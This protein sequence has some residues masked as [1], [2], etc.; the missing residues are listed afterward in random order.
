[1][2][3]VRLQI[4]CA[5]GEETRRALEDILNAVAQIDARIYEKYPLAPCCPKCANMRYQP[6]VKADL[7]SATET[8]QTVDRMMAVRAVRC[9]AL[10]AMVA[11]HEA[12]Q[13]VPATV[14]VE[15]LPGTKQEANNFHAVAM[16]RGR[17][18]D[19]SAEL[20]DAGMTCSCEAP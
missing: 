7:E 13:G 4:G 1:M 9:G 16:I 15:H 5:P 11:G 10:A 8:F 3:E 12:A 17:R 20:I 18:V 19:P 6:T 14:K 2:F